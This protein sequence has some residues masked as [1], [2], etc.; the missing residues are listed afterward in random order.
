MMLRA[1]GRRISPRRKILNQREWNLLDFLLTE[2]EPADPFSDNPSKKLAFTKLNEASYIRTAYGKVT[3]RTFYRE[4]GR[5]AELG[6]LTLTRDD[7]L[8]DW[9]L[10]LDFNAIGRY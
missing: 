4:L 3:A 7:I 5:L 1:F 8:N 6:F 10:E 2:T 9:I